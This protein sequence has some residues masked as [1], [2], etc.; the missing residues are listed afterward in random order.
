M[1]AAALQLVALLIV[2]GFPAFVI[3]R[4]FWYAGSWF[5]R[6]VKPRLEYREEDYE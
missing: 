1:T 5:K 4:F 6:Q 2:C 3:L